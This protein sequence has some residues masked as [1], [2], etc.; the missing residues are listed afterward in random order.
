MCSSNCLTLSSYSALPADCGSHYLG[1]ELEGEEPERE[2][3][4][5]E[6]LEGEDKD[7]GLAH[8]NSDS[9]GDNGVQVCGGVGGRGWEEG[10]RGRVGRGKRKR[11]GGRCDRQERRGGSGSGYLPF[12]VYSV[13]ALVLLCTCV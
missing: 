3:S 8:H 13:L 2:E 9:D 7:G 4:E 5:G 1:E 11:E 10:R 6:E 12:I